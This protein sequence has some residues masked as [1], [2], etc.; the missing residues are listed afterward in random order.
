MGQ[1]VP[2]FQRMTRAPKSRIATFAAGTTHAFRWTPE[3]GLV[4]LGAPPGFPISQGSGINDH[5][6][7]VGLSRS[8]LSDQA[9]RW[10]PGLAPVLLPYARPLST[11]VVLSCQPLLVPLTVFSK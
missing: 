7:V 3:D 10:E 11:Q 1:L 9:T 8:P 2:A 5:G 4:D 6:V